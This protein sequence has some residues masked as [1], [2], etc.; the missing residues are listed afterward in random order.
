MIVKSKR[1]LQTKIEWMWHNDRIQNFIFGENAV[2]I[3]VY[4]KTN[5][6]FSI[7]KPVKIMAQA[8]TSMSFQLSNSLQVTGGRLKPSCNKRGRQYWTFV[9]FAFFQ[10]NGVSD[11]SELWG[12]RCKK[13]NSSVFSPEKRFDKKT[14]DRD[15]GVWILICSYGDT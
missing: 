3:M 5:R 8:I 14:V 13:Q 6:T 15:L 11:I 10:A 7:F 4:V 1:P 12:C 2:W 9:R